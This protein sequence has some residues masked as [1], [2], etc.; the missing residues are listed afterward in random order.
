LIVATGAKWRE[1][2]VP[3]EKENIGNGVAYCPHCD[4]PFFKGKDVAVIGGGNSG[5]EAA[6]DLAGIVKSVTVL[7]FGDT[8]R[9]DQVLIN[10][11]EKRDNISIIKS[12]AT[13]EVT[14]A[15][16]KVNGLKYLDRTSDEVKN[17]ALDGIFV[18][19]GLVPNSA[20]VKDV[21]ET[22]QYGEII[23][24]EKCHTSSKGIYAAG[25]V[26]TVPYKQIVIAMG[27]GSKASLSAFEYLLANSERLEA[28]Y[29]EQ[30]ASEE[31][32]A[33]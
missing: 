32:V 16:G 27:E 2:N 12:A 33:A 17:V 22:S 5:I 30:N 4:G 31:S 21:I 13:Q 15:D 1:L 25:D 7:E 18:Q 29:A 6:L 24:D 19:I 10:Q 20:F 3:G 8:L 9:A 26:S 14:A 11:A 23:I 28:L